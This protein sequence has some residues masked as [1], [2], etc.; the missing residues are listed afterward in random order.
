M[1]NKMK[2]M[3]ASDKNGYFYTHILMV[4]LYD[5]TTTTIYFVFCYIFYKSKY[6]HFCIL[7]G[8]N[9]NLT[10]IYIYI[11]Q[12][13]EAINYGMANILDMSCFCGMLRR[14]YFFNRQ[15][16]L[17]DFFLLLKKTCLF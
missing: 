10:H 6:S 15:G 3:S 5:C 7:F 9:S 4:Y 17:S 16:L 12:I 13:W 11:Y 14:R 8:L 2:I 1:S